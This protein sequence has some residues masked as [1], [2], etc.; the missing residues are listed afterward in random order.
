METYKF[1]EKYRKLL[2]YKILV[3]ELIILMTYKL[4]LFIISKLSKGFQ[5]DDNICV[6]NLVLNK[7]REDRSSLDDR[8][9]YPRDMLQLFK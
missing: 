3:T 1:M 4:H 8:K 5:G 2:C 7:K 9:R 6:Q